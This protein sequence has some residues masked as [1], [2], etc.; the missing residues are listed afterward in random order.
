MKLMNKES[1]EE[2]GEIEERLDKVLS[3]F[4]AFEQK[5]HMNSAWAFLNPRLYELLSQLSRPVL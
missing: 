4:R 1:V 2:M 5:E 3:K